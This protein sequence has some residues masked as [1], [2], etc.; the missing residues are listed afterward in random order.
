VKSQKLPHAH[1]TP[2][3]KLLQAQ[4]QQQLFKVSI[5]DPTTL[6]PP[7]DVTAACLTPQ[8]TLISPSRAVSDTQGYP[9]ASFR[10]VTATLPTHHT[11]PAFVYI[12][13]CLLCNW[14]VEKSDILKMKFNKITT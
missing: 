8:S 1:L 3:L 4:P 5:S 9:S 6:K 2:L 13:C 11:S 12:L 10:A 14:I 7:R